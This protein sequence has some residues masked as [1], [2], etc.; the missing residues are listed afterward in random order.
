MAQAQR[1]AMVYSGMLGFLLSEANDWRSRDQFEVDNEGGTEDM[2]AGTLLKAGATAADPHV[3]WDG[4]GDVT[5]ILAQTLA[6]GAADR[7]TV[8]TRQ[9]EVKYPDL[10]LPA[11]TDEQEAYAAL[12][13]LGIIVRWNEGLKLK[14]SIDIMDY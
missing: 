14:P 6:A 10:K 2:L 8:I 5:G 3:A 12:L 1:I 4:T 13:P 11:G 9:A 7:R